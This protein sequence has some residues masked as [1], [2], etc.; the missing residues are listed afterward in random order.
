VAVDQVDDLLVD[1]TAQHHLHHVHGLAVGDPHALHETDSLPM[2]QQLPIC[3]PPPCTT[4]G[5]HAH[6]LHQHDIAG[7]ALLSV[8]STMA[9][10]PY[11]TTTVLPLKRWI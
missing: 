5:I 7:E 6:Q 11:L 9:L 8:S 4:T 2:R 1:Q 3:G 10:P